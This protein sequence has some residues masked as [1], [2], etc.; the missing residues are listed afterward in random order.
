VSQVVLNETLSANRFRASIPSGFLVTRDGVPPTVRLSGGT[1]AQRQIVSETVK[2]ATE[3][4]AQGPPSSP[5]IPWPISPR[6]LVPLGFL[7]VIVGLFV[8]RRRSHAVVSQ[9]H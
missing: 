2:S 8:L 7:V 9:G 6:V 1:Q 3:L 4:L 5:E